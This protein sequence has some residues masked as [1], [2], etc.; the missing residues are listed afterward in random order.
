ME[1]AESTGRLLAGLVYRKITEDKCGCKSVCHFCGPRLGSIASESAALGLLSVPS[2]NIC[3]LLSSTCFMLKGA[4]A[5]QSLEE[6]CLTSPVHLGLRYEAG[7]WWANSRVLM[8]TEYC[9]DKLCCMRKRG[10]RGQRCSSVTEHSGCQE[11]EMLG[12]T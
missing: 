9:P 8:K 5:G 7:E 2:F 3:F 1:A 6:H 4:G 12:L 10:L 11:G